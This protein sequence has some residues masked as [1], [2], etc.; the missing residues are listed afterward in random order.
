MG[1]FLDLKRFIFFALL[2]LSTGASEVKANP[3]SLY[4]PE[5][6]LAFKRINKVVPSPNGKE[7]AYIISEHKQYKKNSYWEFQLYLR[8]HQ[9]V[10]KLLAKG[11]SMSA[12][13]WSPDGSSV[14]FISSG[15]KYR[16]VVV[17]D[18]ANLD[19]SKI[20][21]FNRDIASFKWSPDGKSIAFIANDIES[22][23]PRSSA[24]LDVGQHFGYARL[25][26]ISLSDDH[27]MPKPLTPPTYSL[28][29]H[30]D[31]SPDNQT[32][33]FAFQP[34]PGSTYANQSKIA[35]VNIKNQAITPLGYTQNHVGTMPVFSPDGK[36]IA[37]QSNLEGSTRARTIMNDIELNNRVCVASLP[38]Q[39][40]HCLATTFNENPVILGWNPTSD[41][42]YVYEEYKT[43][44]YEIYS[45]SL[46]ANKPVMNVSNIPG[47]IEPLTISLNQTGT[48]FGFGYETSD[49]APEIYI[50][51]AHPFN[52]QQ[53]SQ[54]QSKVAKK[55]L[56]TTTLM[57]WKSAGGLEIEGLLITP[58]NY[59]PQK[60]YPLVVTLHGGPA[61]S[62]SQ[63]YLG[64]CDEYDTMVDPTSCWGNLTSLGFVVLAPNIRGSTGYG[65]EFRAANFADFGG[66]DY[67]DVLTGID[68]L[69][70]KGIV[71]KDHLAI[72]G[73]SFGGY[74]TAWA[75]SQTD[76]FKAAVDGAGNTDFISFSGTSDIP[77]YYVKYLGIP[78]WDDN[79]LYL[80]NAPI[81]YVKNIKTPLLILH[82]ENDYRVPVSQSYELYTALRQQNKQVKFFVLPQQAHVPTDPTVISES[83]NQ[84]DSW[85]KRAL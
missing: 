24:L 50:A 43:K 7:V 49:Q 34:Q 71:D 66:G 46:D 14:G 44:G 48:V 11:E 80:Q 37:F 41:Q 63:R 81:T 77:Y 40:T 2:F 6:I 42:I 83:I 67:Q 62:W 59:N 73:W 70:E 25:Y 21:E 64:G 78:F 10:T 82:G 65:K 56:G 15:E 51:T 33:V 26:W 52:L 57:R 27:S 58:P 4:S 45:L 13:A 20:L 29:Q 3:S 22:N 30:F 69:V 39:A 79:K 55:K 19:N 5:Q 85:L 75:I 17:M 84:V 61:G 47:F 53:V 8:D 23:A 16:S 1:K 32:I 31:W 18:L 38:T 72:A 54:L 9:G 74:M 68:S 36:W 60:K 28:S 12:L 35:M 76:R